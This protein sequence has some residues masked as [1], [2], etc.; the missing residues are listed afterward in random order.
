MGPLC[1][2]GVRRGRKGGRTWGEGE[3]E[4]RSVALNKC[5]FVSTYPQFH[6][7]AIQLTIS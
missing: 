6:H 7:M 1:G 5:A 3:N 2:G 4:G